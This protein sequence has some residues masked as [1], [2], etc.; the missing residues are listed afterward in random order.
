MEMTVEQREELLAQF[1]TQDGQRLDELMRRRP[2]LLV[3]LRH[4]GCTFCRESLADL[5]RQ[6]RAIEQGGAQ[7]AIVHLSDEAEAAAMFQ[8]YQ[9]DDLPRISDP[10]GRLYRAFGLG[11][12]RWR[13]L[14]AP[15][16][17]WRGIQS[18]FLEGHGFA[19]ATQNVTQ[20]PG[21]FLLN[22]GQVVHSFRHTTPADRP[23]YGALARQCARA[24]ADS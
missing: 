3:F 21:V 12:G 16:V 1:V 22:G 8:H 20:M 4:A 23:D 13:Q 24:T 18:A 5:R 6:R 14:L 10:Q 7:I 19:P 11:Q 9:V 17:W 15:K 2:L